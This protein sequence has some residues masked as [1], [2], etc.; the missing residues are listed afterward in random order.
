MTQEQVINI[1]RSKGNVGCTE[2]ERYIDYPDEIDG[3]WVQVVHF[4]DDRG[5]AVY[6]VNSETEQGEFI[7]YADYSHRDELEKYL[8]TINK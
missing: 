4:A 8:E 2:T 3:D 6:V 7:E 5:L 1:V